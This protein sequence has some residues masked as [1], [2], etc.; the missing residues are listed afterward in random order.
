M[1]TDSVCRSRARGASAVELAL[2]LPVFMILLM[3][4]IFFGRVYWHYTVAQK[5]AQDA[6]R[7]LSSVSY[8]EM[9]SSRLAPAAAAIARQI[10]EI[11]MAELSPGGER[12]EVGIYC[13]TSN[14]TGL[15]SRPA[16][17]YVRVEIRINVF[18]TMFGVV[19]TGRY[20]LPITVNVSMPYVGQ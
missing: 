10:A 1:R 15:G 14:C 13:G 11:E 3:F 19:D 9:R 18:D 8:Q 6:A 7:Y 5:A 17:T 20:G 4:P 12:P 16:P 2:L